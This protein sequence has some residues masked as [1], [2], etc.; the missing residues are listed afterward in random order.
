MRNVKDELLKLMNNEDT[1]NCWGVDYWD[2]DQSD[3]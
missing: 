1:N 2:E 3:P